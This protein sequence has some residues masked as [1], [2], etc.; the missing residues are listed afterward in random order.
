[1]S[2]VLLLGLLS[3]PL[4]AVAVCDVGVVGVSGVVIIT[5]DGF[6]IT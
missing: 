6:G 3:L 5:A 2:F 4:V 1:M